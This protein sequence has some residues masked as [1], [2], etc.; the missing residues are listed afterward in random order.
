MGYDVIDNDFLP[1]QHV[2]ADS[3]AP[4]QV[5]Y[6][7]VSPLYNESGN[8]AHLVERLDDVMQQ[9]EGGRFEIILV[10]DGSS[11]STWREIDA[12]AKRT[13]AVV[14]V[15][16]SRNF[17]HQGA[18]MAGL[19]L[20]RGKATITIDGDLQH[21]PELIPELIEKWRRGAKIV[22]TQRI[23]G[24]VVS[25]FKRTTSRW[26]Y[27][28]LGS[29]S[30]AELY[31]GSSDF[32][33]IDRR[34]LDELLSLRYGHLFLRG[35]V[36]TLGFSTAKVPYQVAERFSGQSKY[37][38]RKMLGFARNGVISHSKAPLRLGV[39]LGLATGAL[40]LVEVVYVLVQAFRGNRSPV[41]RRRSA[42]C[43]SCFPCCFS[44][45]ESSGYIWRT[46]IAC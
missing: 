8:V 32:R 23:D 20:A 28:L 21:P 44:C 24:A 7:I 39:Y 3:R 29:L 5:I 13:P 31:A 15:R 33:L 40:S 26:F 46:F 22:L 19:S 34:A 30:E 4:G 41:G 45:W 9:V 18:L 43:R 37:T 38:L 25:P 6:S 14:G 2:A 36:Q 16:L 11:N 42:S 12:A 17:G 10:D 27:K 1:L 35:A